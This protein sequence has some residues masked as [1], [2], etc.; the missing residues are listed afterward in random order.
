MQI[1][2]KTLTGKAITLEVESCDTIDNVKAKIQDK[3]FAFIGN[4]NGG[5]KS[6]AETNM[7]HVQWQQSEVAF[8]TYSHSRGSLIQFLEP[9]KRD[10]KPPWLQTPVWVAPPIYGHTFTPSSSKLPR[11]YTGILSPQV[12][13]T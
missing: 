7:I 12:R 2:V 8:E 6:W 9:T 3:G 10:V 5:M 4:D 1:F 11:Q 13:A